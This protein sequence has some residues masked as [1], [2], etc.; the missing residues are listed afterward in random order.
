MKLIAYGKEFT[1]RIVEWKFKT[2]DFDATATQKSR[3]GIMALAKS[4][5]GKLI[6]IMLAVYTLEF[7][8]AATVTTV[9]KEN[10]I[11]GLLTWTTTEEKKV[12]KYIDKKAIEKFQNFFR[13]KAL[14][15]FEQEGIIDKI[16][17]TDHP[18]LH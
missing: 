8:L 13:L 1:S 9:V 15:A 17:Y 3:Y 4:S 2:D 5:D 14:K 16:S 6:D 18:A 10:A 12:N 7:K 11:M